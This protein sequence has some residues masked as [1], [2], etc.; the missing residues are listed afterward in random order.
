MSVREERQQPGNPSLQGQH[1]Q[2]APREK[3][4]LEAEI[5]PQQRGQARGAEYPQYTVRKEAM[6][7]HT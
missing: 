2:V 5:K 6:A 4:A 7:G 1:S 3:T